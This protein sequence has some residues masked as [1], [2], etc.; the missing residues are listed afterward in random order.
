MWTNFVFAV[1]ISAIF[2]SKSHVK[3]IGGYK[4][5]PMHFAKPLASALEDILLA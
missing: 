5:K 1:L 3:A 4:C 2:T